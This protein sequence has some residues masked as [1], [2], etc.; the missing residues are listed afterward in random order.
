[1]APKPVQKVIARNNVSSGLDQ[2]SEQIEFLVGQL[3]RLTFNETLMPSEGNADPPDSQAF[4]SLLL[5][6]ADAGSILHEE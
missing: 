6:L 2:R 5:F 1:M 4:L 3:D